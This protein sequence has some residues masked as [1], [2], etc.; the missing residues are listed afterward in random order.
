MTTFSILPFAD[1]N[2]FFSG[3][4]GRKKLSQ[5]NLCRGNHL[6][7]YRSNLLFLCL[8]AYPFSIQCCV[9][10]HKNP[11]NVLKFFTIFFSL[12]S[13]HLTLFLSRHLLLHASIT[14][15]EKN[16][17]SMW[18]FQLNF[19][20]RWVLLHNYWKW[21]KF[22]FMNTKIKRKKDKS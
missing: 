6:N 7:N 20:L 11:Y 10:G 9:D 19:L 16:V 5:V 1:Y 18:E 17:N 8:Y 2:R 13:I 14:D 15:H 12:S 4:K 21:Y 3:Q 22:F